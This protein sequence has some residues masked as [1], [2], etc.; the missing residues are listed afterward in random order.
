MAHNHKEERRRKEFGEWLR[1]HREA[2]RPPLSQTEAGKRAGMSRTQ[3]TRIE[4]GESGTKRENIPLI[5][6]AVGADLTQTYIRAGF[7]PPA[8]PEA[9]ADDISVRIFNISRELPPETRITALGVMEAIWRGEIVKANEPVKP[10]AKR[11]PPKTA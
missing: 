10:V 1:K 3:W 11:R 6:R 7:N 8:E 2:M 4:H 5:A 9:E